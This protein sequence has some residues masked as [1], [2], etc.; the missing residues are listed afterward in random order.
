MVDNQSETDP[1]RIAMLELKSRLVP[2]IIRRHLP[3]GT[4][5]DWRVDELIN[6]IQ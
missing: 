6:E 2:F 3:D 4:F 1:L 5:E